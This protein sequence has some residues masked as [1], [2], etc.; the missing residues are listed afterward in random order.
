MTDVNDEL[1]VIH[2]LEYS[3]SWMGECFVS[4]DFKRQSPIGFEIG[5]YI[6][7]RGERFELNYVPG[8]EKQAR[9]DTYG[10][11]FTYDG[12]K[13]NSLRDELSRAEFLDVVLHDNQLHYTTLPK[14]PF[15]VETI[16]D[17]LDRIQAN[18][19]EQIGDGKWKIF[20]RNKE[21]SMQRGCTA[22][23][24][25]AVYG[26]G[27]NDSASFE[28][29][30]I[31][32]DTQ[33]CWDALALVNTQWNINFVIR[34]R[35]IYV[36]TAG[37]M[38]DDIFKYGLGK[39]LYKVDQNAD[40]DQS[41]I[42]RLRAYGS[43]KNLPDHYYADLG[44]KYKVGITKV[45]NAASFVELY[46]DLD[47]IST[48]FTEP[49][50]YISS[51]STGE[52]TN[53]FVLRATFDFKTIITGYVTGTSNNK[54]RF[55]SGL[56]GSQTDNGDEES[57]DALDAFISQVKSGSYTKLYITSG[58]NE[59]TIPSE[60]K[61]YAENLPNNMAISRLMLP[62]FPTLSL[63]EFW[64]TMTEEEKK[65][66]NPTGKEHI[67]SNDKYR[68]YIDSLNIDK[69]GLRSDSKFFDTDDKANGI[70]EIYPTI[71]EMV[72]GGVRVDEI[73]KGSE[74]DDDG[75]F[76]DGQSVKNID[77]YLNPAI[78]FDI[79]N[80]KD[81]D[82]SICMKDG[83]CGGR[84]FKVASSTKE[85]GT[86]RLTIERVKDDALGLYF[87]YKDYQIKKNDHF[88]LTGI[89]LPD[90]Y[91][92]AA[93]LKL[94]K[95][96]IAL[97][98]K[99]DYTRYVYQPKL[100]ITS[101]INE[102]TIP[103]ENKEYAENLP[104]NMAI[105]R[106]ML[107]GFPTLSLREF[108]D[109]MTE[110]EKKY[111]NPTGKEH[112]FS[113][114]KYRPYIDSLNIDKIGLR[115]DSKF[116]DT[117]DKA[118]GIV[119]IYP[120][121]EEMVVGGVRVDEIYKGSEVDDD[122]RFV[123]GQSVKN[124][125][126]Y[127]NPAIDFDINNLK[128]DDF[129]ICM[130]D[131]MCGGRSFKVA[132]ST[133]ESGTWRLTIER[134]KDDAL[135]LYFPYKD[136]Q[137]KKND[138]FVLTGIRLPDSYVRAA[139]LKLLKYAIALLDKND[140]TR[141]VYQPK[142]DDI[143]MA[144]QHDAAMADK[145][146][147]TR[148][149][150]D[151]L[152]AGDIMRLSDDDL[153]IKADVTIDQIIIKEEDGKIPAYEITLREEKEVGTIQK[154]QQSISSL[155][156]GNGVASEPTI[157]QVK[158]MFKSEGGRYF[159][160]KLEDDVASGAITFEKMQKFLGGFVSAGR[161]ILQK[162][163]AIDENGYGFDENGNIIADSL[164]SIGFDKVLNEGFGMEMDGDQSHL[165][166]ANLTVWGKMM[167]NILEIMKTKYAGGNIYMSA[168]GGTIVKAVPV[169]YINEDV[170]WEETSES[171]CDG[172][173]CYILADDGDE[174]TTNPWVEGD[175]VRCQSMGNLLGT[176]Y[177]KAT[178]KSYWRTIP[179]HG[180]SSFNE[181]I[182][183]DYGTPAYNGK[184]FY[185]I[186]LG[187][188]SKDFDG[189]T[190]ENAPVG[191]TDIPEAGDSIVLDGCRKDTSRQG[192]L[193]LSSYGS[194]AP[195]IVGLR[196]V[197]D[198]THEKCAIFELSYDYVRIFAERFK[199]IA[200]D[201]KVVEITNFRGEWD[202]NEKYYK[203]DQVSHNNA[204]WTCIKDADFQTEPT[205][206]STYWRKEVYG[207]KGEDGSS[208]K[209][210]GTAVK[211][212]TNADDIG[213][214]LLT[215]KEYL[216]DDTSGLPD[217]VASPCI[218]TYMKIGA[219][220][221]WIICKS[222]DGDSYMIGDDLWTNSG[223]AW[224]NIGNVKGVSISSTSVTYGVSASGTQQPS[225][226][227]S[228]IPPTTDVYPYLW[229]RTMVNYT[230]GKSTTSF[231]VSHNG[232]D[233]AKGDPGD[234]GADAITI[235]LVGAPLIFDA[236]SDGI[237]P[238]GVTNY[239]RLYVTVGEKD[240]SEYVGQPYFVPSEGMNVSHEDGYVI[241][242]REYN[243]KMAWYLGIKS[244]AI[245]KVYLS[246]NKTEVSATSGYIT[247][248]FAYGANQYVGQ[249]PFQVNVARYTGELTLTNT[250]FKVSMDGLTTRMVTAEENITGV[251]TKLNT[252][253]KTLHAEITSTANDIKLEVTEQMNGNLKK[254][255]LEVKADG[256]ILYGDKITI[257][258]D[259]GKTTTALFANG[260]IN[261]SLIDADQ[262]EVK[263]LWAKSNDGASKVG[264]FG[265]TEESACKLSDGTLAPLFIGGDTA[266]KSPFYVTSKGAMHATSGYIGGFSINQN[267]L[268]YGNPSKWATTK[269]ENLAQVGW[270]FIR[271]AQ[272]I[273]NGG[274]P[275][276]YQKIGIG[277]NAYPGDEED[278]S[279]VGST[280]MYIY[281]SMLAYSEDKAYKPAAIIES[282]NAQNRN[283]ALKL[284]GG[285]QVHG[286]VIQHGCVMT[287][288]KKG[289]ANVLNLS[290]S[291]IFTLRNTMKDSMDFFFP[292]LPEVRQQLGIWSAD[293]EF[294]IPVTVIAAAN[295]TQ[296]AIS[297]Q[298]SAA[299]TDL[300]QAD[301][302]RYVD[303]NGMWDYGN[304]KG[305]GGNRIVMR[306]GDCWSFSLT[307][308]KAQGYY[309]QIL[310][311]Q[312]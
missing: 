243:E 166:L 73:Y 238:K 112:I 229:T 43:E 202:P 114:D 122:G 105:S 215:T 155:E 45:G 71:E 186:V 62:G 296:F 194:G 251:N 52:Q 248:V 74:V 56:K 181:Y 104:N 46:L 65:Y 184:M 1:V 206:G 124:I 107:P 22:E 198:Y 309:I 282:D 156:S 78:D 118:N 90:S 69:I 139:S 87:P 283:I 298:L 262:I 177:A 281:R 203:N 259:D 214:E 241:E 209:V 174:A 300:T 66:V 183:N 108:W 34:G 100:Y 132:S 302:G 10:E 27:T 33:K 245:S 23:E 168:A 221:T 164:K 14:F 163:F 51:G 235:Q 258:N 97:L 115:S 106:L 201:N 17:L 113:N 134:V 303:N 197:S 141:Y 91:V 153:G 199:L 145:S 264:Y 63:R 236:G 250:Q 80:L 67:F 20:S 284:I 267:S 213:G 293:V 216:F 182:Y 218:A 286:G 211:H 40:S 126:I 15:Y 21:R 287:Y 310:N 254:A 170:G 237:A 8:K 99:N 152:R 64:D 178:N 158:S 249:L 222:N 48:Y 239:A 2:G 58:I 246:D 273:A 86:W 101:G 280:A 307:F 210:L 233:G 292:S 36:G 116:F 120:T 9:K 11:G 161:A 151:T 131:G 123:D 294:C 225:S 147:A 242:R 93:S 82:F 180:V 7:Y 53:G 96:A 54:C 165:Y 103:S 44:I 176:R 160:S 135:G 70:V 185:W 263:H 121:I 274:K 4:I 256:I 193:Q 288:E 89:R 31:T 19:N 35:N 226:W 79:N 234:K 278:S 111:V 275:I 75:R 191:T 261:A 188:H 240:V 312:I 295:T 167:I 169:T 98:D 127:L 232:K 37:V 117:D 47:Y 146:G 272:A 172:W 231:S 95:Y 230:D 190:E 16:D 28:S 219:G 304:D 204:I 173:K 260:K 157:A 212:F 24:W 148:S 285:L 68:P 306:N 41:I 83:M 257:T 25:N 265:N 277:G 175:Q 55:Y 85:S 50:K 223:T 150:H 39:G 187:K 136:Y 13:F 60:N 129:S 196:G 128:D 49:R 154:I 276:A 220:H 269:T 109:T 130:K 252:E 57:K 72:V 171:W 217:G 289:D 244:D 205:D 266:A 228:I 6:M 138:H 92:R 179:E 59:K 88:V 29:K 119:E 32:I 279:V 81:D 311:T 3:D 110:E 162:G 227:S 247:F 144:R 192:V 253:V 42:T 125:D 61:E 305:Y 189:Y 200:K 255:G 224:L 84:S 207:Q 26:D 76:V 159:L 268:Y 297:T 102:K 38:T 142:V 291:T 149:L 30:S 208:F 290:F 308:T 299:N 18:L 12:V 94:L 270:N 301:G 143:F 133:K 5:D 271:I 195:S 77:I 140:Y 137:I